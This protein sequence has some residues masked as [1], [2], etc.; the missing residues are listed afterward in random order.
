MESTCAS[1][2]S[3]PSSF[4]VEVVSET[5]KVVLFGRFEVSQPLNVV[6]MSWVS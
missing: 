3:F 1:D 6:V 5:C 4:R 2:R